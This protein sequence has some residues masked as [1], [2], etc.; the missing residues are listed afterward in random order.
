MIDPLLEV[1]ALPN[2]ASLINRGCRGN[3]ATIR[4]I[5]SPML[6][7]SIAT[8]KRADKHGIHGFAEP[9]PDATGVRPVT[10]TSRTCKALWNICSQQGLKSCIINWFASHPAEPIDGVV[11]SDAYTALVKPGVGDGGGVEIPEGTVHP[12]ELAAPLAR[13]LVDPAALDASALLPF[14]PRA[15]EIDQ[16]DDDRLIRLA[17]LLARAATVQAAACFTLQEKPWD[18]ACLYFGAIDEFGHHFM[19]YHPP[20]LPGVDVRDGEIFG[21]VMEGC[22]RFHDMM[23]GQLL[24]IAGDDTTVMLVSDHGFYHD[25]GRPGPRGYDAPEQWHRPF[26]VG[27][28]A[29]P[30]VKQGEQIY[31]GTILDVTPT[32]L[33]L[34]GLPVSMDMDGRP[35]GEA[36]DSD[37]LPDMRLTW[38]DP[39]MA[40]G[41]RD[42]ESA[43]S[44][45]STGAVDDPVVAAQAMR[46]L[47]DL[48]YVDLPQGGVQE[49]IDRT[50]ELQRYNLARALSDSRRASHAID[51]W[52]QLSL[53]HPDKP[54]YRFELARCFAQL[55]R[56]D[57]ALEQIQQLDAMPGIRLLHAKVLMDMG[58]LDHA[59]ELVQL[60]LEETPDSL[61]ALTRAAQIHLQRD[62]LH[63]ARRLLDRAAEQDGQ[64][65]LIAD[66]LSELALKDKRYPDAIGHALDAVELA[67]FFPK[68][69]YHLGC[70]LAA[71][72]DTDHAILALQTCLGL[73]PSFRPARQKLAHLLPAGHKHISSSRGATKPVKS[74]GP[75]V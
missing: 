68:A 73:A 45:E 11:V 27:V 42:T 3:V 60:Q 58:Q 38:D 67:H 50:I 23:L 47:A 59:H 54:G 39:V 24:A 17:T 25:A 64:N 53:D 9:K 29:G 36:L 35:W 10:S 7:T 37:E 8:G 14:V 46:H 4:P 1:G 43:E 5:L 13:L 57:E 19:P 20:L 51:L 26:G 33:R 56:Y 55:K 52:K 44:A 2:L 15:A 16:R 34:F 31:G 40:S 21:P 61:V 70:A 48:G 49:Q 74:S 62:E 72:G 69:H 30:G 18:L 63:D 71:T 41:V 28:L 6:W 32:I 75:S 65:P 66:A 22:Y 12:A